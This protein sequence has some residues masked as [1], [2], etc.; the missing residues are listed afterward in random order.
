MAKGR[1]HSGRGRKL[2]SVRRH[3]SRPRG[4]KPPLRRVSK[5]GAYK[6]AQ[7]TNFMRKRAALVETKKKTTSEISKVTGI[8]NLPPDFKMPF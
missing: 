2:G 7:K 8:P 4:R 5:R 6:K 3:S 1:E